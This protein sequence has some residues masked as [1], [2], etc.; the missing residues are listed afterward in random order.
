MQSINK[1]DREYTPKSF[2]HQTPSSDVNVDKDNYKPHK[3]TQETQMSW[4]P[5]LTSYYL[6]PQ[7]T[8][9][10]SNATITQVNKGENKG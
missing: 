7:N 1:I 6:N 10:N 8:L 5:S 3:Y 2:L 9:S 4:I